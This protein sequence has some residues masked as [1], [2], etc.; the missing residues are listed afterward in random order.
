MDS[1]FLENL[2]TNPTQLLGLVAFASAAIAC[3]FA[4]NSSPYEG[5]AW[6]VLAAI[7]AV[8]FAEILFGIRHHLHADVVSF[9]LRMGLYE[10]RADLQYGLMVGGATIP[11][12]AALSLF[13]FSEF[14]KPRLIVATFASFAVL[15][16]F[17]IEA[18][19]F[20][21]IDETFYQEVGPVMLIGWLWCAACVATILSAR[22]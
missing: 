17:A 22:L 16:L 12:L 1:E 15:T 14:R 7:N 20:H 6:I 13:F 19:S 18:I 10:N 9:L 3:I 5:R 11:I 21:R 4:K 8:F 2:G